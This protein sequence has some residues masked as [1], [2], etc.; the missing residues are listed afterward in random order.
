M[1]YINCSSMCSRIYKN[2][3]NPH[4]TLPVFILGTENGGCVTEERGVLLLGGVGVGVIISPPT[5][6][7]VVIRKII[8]LKIK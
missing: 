8:K 5:A 6:T 4:H 7:A 1:E 3:C 2:L